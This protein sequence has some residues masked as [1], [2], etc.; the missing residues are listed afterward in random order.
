MGYP[1][2]DKREFYKGMTDEDLSEQLVAAKEHAATLRQEVWYVE[3]E[4]RDRLLQ[5]N[6]TVILAGKWKV[7][8]SV[9]REV[10]WDQSALAAAACV[11]LVQGVGEEFH[12]SF[13]L[14]YG[15]SVRNL[16]ALLKLGG[17]TAQAIEA[18]RGEVTEKVTITVEALSSGSAR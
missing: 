12:R 2:S 18:A 7:K 6:A 9:K 4:I 10:K 1:G 13:P 14:E 15:C 16:N 8:S 11:S 17:A 3:D 5:R